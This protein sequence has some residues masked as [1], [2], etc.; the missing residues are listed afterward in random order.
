[1]AENRGNPSGANN[2]PSTRPNGVTR[3]RSNSSSS[4]NYIDPKTMKE[5]GIVNKGLSHFAETLG[6]TL[7]KYNKLIT[8]SSKDLV[9]TRQKLDKE[10]KELDEQLVE[11]KKHY[12]GKNKKAYND[13]EKQ[14]EMKKVEMEKEY[15]ELR[16]STRKEFLKQQIKFEKE[17]N[18]KKFVESEYVKNNPNFKLQNKYN[19]ELAKLQESFL[20][21]YGENYR[22]T[23]DYNNA[24]KELNKDS[25]KWGLK[26]SFKTSTEKKQFTYIDSKFAKNNNLKSISNEYFNE[27]EKLKSSAVDAYGDKYATSKEYKQ[28]LMN[29]NDK[30]AQDMKES[31]KEDFKE[32]HKVLGGVADG[33]K[34]T[35]EKNKEV[36]QGFLGPLN[37][38]ITP[39]KEFFG[40][41]GLI[42]KGIKG[43]AKWLVGKFTKKN[44]TATD[45]MKSGAMGVGA[46]WI[47]NK[48]DKLLGTD[49]KEKFS[50]NGGLTSLLP[51]QLQDM[52][53]E[54][55]NLIKNLKLISGLGGGLLV[56]KDF[57]EEFAKTGDWR[58]AVVKG[59]TG[60]SKLENAIKG[61]LIG[62]SI[63]GPV[64]ALVG[65]LGGVALNYFSPQ[66][67]AFIRTLT[68][69]VSQKK[70]N[71]LA[72][73]EKDVSKGKRSQQELDIYN[74]LAPV[75]TDAE[76]ASL[77]KGFFESEKSNRKDWIKQY[78][79]GNL[80]ILSDEELLYMGNLFMKNGYDTA[81]K[82]GVDN[83][84]NV[85]G[86]LGNL[87]D[88]TLAS[89]SQKPET[90][91]NFL[92]MIV[93]LNSTKSMSGQDLSKWLK[94][95]GISTDRYNQL[96]ESSI[97]QT[98]DSTNLES[99]KALMNVIDPKGKAKFDSS[100]LNYASVDDAIIK[101]DGSI[102]KTNPKDTLV[103]LKDVP[104]SIDKVREENNKNL[105]TNLS[106]MERD[107]TL[108][109]KLTTIIEV[110]SK[111]LAKDVCVQL[112]PQTRS[113]LDMLM[114]GGMI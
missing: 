14:I 61:A 45:V 60:S 19:S 7:E 29:L 106:R 105:N 58:S 1:M 88:S 30:Y 79:K 25:I 99:I 23:Q 97:M 91:S 54:N 62:F 98:L 95:N 21:V 93:T 104:L 35:F 74:K 24:L 113:D 18:D 10:S 77:G 33:I 3:D 87:N 59:V 51:K 114:S 65:A 37:L 69:D 32:N 101:T 38:I 27:L 46:L 83:F 66:V 28:A 39:I 36:L 31:W 103:A 40:G 89:I 111:L 78:A 72:N 2:V 16:I 20:E 15:E 110:L 100:D 73:V 57:V 81:N 68:G 86:V 71:I 84:K 34:D 76:F 6:G 55:S 11:M 80:D 108:E 85:L 92:K 53:G 26:E 112:P 12:F 41:F 96:M 56:I 4:F 42:F 63:G 8:K 9:E 17:Q 49:N 70:K 5:I 75:M 107:G 82:I 44:P 13:Y 67:E 94:T 48:L 50:L 22:H 47:G 109:K 64:G 43:G 102:I 52:L 90:L